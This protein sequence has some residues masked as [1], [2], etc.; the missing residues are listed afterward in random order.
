[1]RPHAKRGALHSLLGSPNKQKWSNCSAT[2]G[3]LSASLRCEGGVVRG[4]QC[5]LICV[6]EYAV[7]VRRRKEGLPE[8]FIPY[9]AREHS[10]GL[11]RP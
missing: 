5:T 11:R 3:V 8:L 4:A 10:Q 7:Y 9:L 2:H 1:V 6:P